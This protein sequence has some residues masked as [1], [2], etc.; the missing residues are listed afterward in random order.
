MARAVLWRSVRAKI[1]SGRG[2]LEP[3]ENLGRQAVAFADGTDFPELKASTALDLA[4]VLESAGNTEEAADL[5]TQA[6]ELYEGK[7]NVVAAK[8]CELRSAHPTR[9]GGTD[10]GR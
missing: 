4:D 3:A 10:D 7:G 6:R 1:L 9:T 2:E 8:Q 5:V